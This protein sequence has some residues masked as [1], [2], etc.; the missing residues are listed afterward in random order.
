MQFFDSVGDVPAGFGPSA[1]TIGK[2]D[3]VHLGHRRVIERLRQ[4]ADQ[5]GLV[6]TALTFD[7]NPLVLL[8]PELAPAPLTSNAQKRE[9]L[10]LA[11]LDAT[12]M[13]PFTREFSQ[14]AP[15]AFVTDILVGAL[16]A[17]V[18]F[19]GEGFR[20]GRRAAGSAA[21]L[22]SMG[23]ELGF[24][25]QS[26]D[27][28]EVDGGPVS[29]T[30]IREALLAGDI[31]TAIRLLGREPTLRGVVVRGE[32]RGRAMGYP[33]ANLSP[34]LEGFVPV[35]GVYAAGLAVDGRTMPAAVSIGNNPTFAGVP[36]KQVEAHVLDEDL[37]L[38]DRTVEL[39]FVDYVRPM[40]KFDGMEDLKAGIAD[41]VRR[42]REIFGAAEPTPS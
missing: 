14:E 39:A 8:R 3:G 21:T 19:V 7:R 22:R 13:V 41:D 23:A 24:E 37:D 34:Q 11:G 9:L 31:R 25:L 18:V 12:L 36:D 26:I 28:V 42:V 27:Q 29:S 2:F 6:A 38:Y 15:E 17:K 20:F 30:R 35:D 16:N 10:E 32:Q 33:T 5:R 1:V 4:E 40:R